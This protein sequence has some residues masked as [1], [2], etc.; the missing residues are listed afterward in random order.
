MKRFGLI[1]ALLVATMGASIASAQESS[2][3][4]GGNALTLGAKSLSFAVPNGGNGYASGAAG[5]WY[6]LAE[7][8]NLGFNV[9][10]GIDRVDNG[11][12]TTTNWD[13]LLA[14]AVRYYLSTSGVVAPYFHGQANLRFHDTDGDNDPEL[15]VAGGIGVEWFPVRN[16]SVG[17]QTGLGIDLIR[18]GSGEP[19]K[20][21][22]FTSA[23]LA[24]I[25]WE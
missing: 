15:G 23:L 1:A 21:A 12:E 16:F 18:S 19:V 20:V 10:L 4:S 13:L 25:Y 8:V 6:M 3:A 11:T 22:T 2:N 7:N 5:F 24:N 14:P 9:G 17:G